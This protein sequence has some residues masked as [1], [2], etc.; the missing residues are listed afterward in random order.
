M[1]RHFATTPYCVSCRLRTAV[2]I[3]GD[4]PR[5]DLATRVILLMHRYEWGRS[6]NTGHLVRLAL[7]NAEIRIHGR[8]RRIAEDGIDPR[9]TLLLFP[10][11]GADILSD[12]LLADVSRPMTLVVPDGNWSQSTHM[13]RRLPMLRGVRCVTLDTPRLG[14]PGLRRNRRADRRSTF[15]AIA[16]ALGVLEG[17]DTT[18]RLL[19]F[20]GQVL[21]RKNGLA[22]RHAP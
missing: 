17:P 6:S 20:L 1:P 9:S 12:E 13:T 14:F 18:A 3:C 15:E 21:A 7:G 19:A 22:V 8:R 4:A 2:C 11:H 5:L 10:S 16:Q